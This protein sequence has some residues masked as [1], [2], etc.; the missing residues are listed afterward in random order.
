MESENYIKDQ[1]MRFN[2]EKLMWVQGILV[3]AIC[4]LAIQIM[5][6]PFPWL[7]Y[8]GIILNGIIIFVVFFGHKNLKQEIDLIKKELANGKK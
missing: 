6:I 4:F 1:R 8:A 3:W 2:K 7:R 5:M